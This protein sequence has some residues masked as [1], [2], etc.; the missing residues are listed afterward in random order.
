MRVLIAGAGIGGL[1]A[2]LCLHAAGFPV[3]LAEAALTF[4]PI[5]VGLNLLPAAVAELA[6][7]GLGDDLHAIAV[8]VAEMAHFDRHGNLIWSEPRDGQYSVHRGELQMML[9]GAVRSRLGHDA[10]RFG[11]AVTAFAPDEGGV[12]TTVRDRASGELTSL[13]A[14]VLI[15][16][17]GLHSTVRRL[18]HAGEGPPLANG[19]TMWRGITPADSTVVLADPAATPLAAALT[20]SAAGGTTPVRGTVAVYGCNAK[21]KLVVYPVAHASGG[22]IHL[23]WVAEARTAAPAQP[24]RAR[25]AIER[26]L[27]SHFEGWSLPHFDVRTL[28]TAA[29]EILELPMTDRDPLPAWGESRVTLLGDAA[30]PMY[31]IGSN[32]GSQ[33]IIDA[34][35]LAT[36]LAMTCDPEAAL[37]AYEQA[38]LPVTSAIVTACR[39][40]PADDIL[41][42]VADRAPHGFTSIADVLT[43]AE[44]ATVT[45]AYTHTSRG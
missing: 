39:A 2:A 32:G 12:T 35:V 36:A 19:I 24:R 34:R 23:N 5:G 21:A 17:D 37:R 20:A 45:A 6:E 26:T 8:P 27:L 43:P 13:R 7:L 31:P 22:R 18:L 40:M 3:T 42:L 28:F 44:L 29:P 14:D 30:H 25:E 11:K 16:A 33:A 4:E 38:R 10:V 9:L 41:T 1:T 15:G